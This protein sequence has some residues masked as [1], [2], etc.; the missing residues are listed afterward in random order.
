MIPK[1]SLCSKIYFYQLGS[2]VSIIYLVLSTQ[3]YKLNED[4]NVLP[5]GFIIYL[6]KVNDLAK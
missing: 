6:Q 2:T 5:H 4:V 3:S 1:C